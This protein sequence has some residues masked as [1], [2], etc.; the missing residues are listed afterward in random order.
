MAGN[1]P[2]RSSRTTK[3]PSAPS[4]QQDQLTPSEKI[5]ARIASLTDWKGEKLAEIRK[6]IH[7]SDPDV[8]EEWK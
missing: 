7:E 1:S 8:I 5:D 3:S 6:L 4:D 2:G